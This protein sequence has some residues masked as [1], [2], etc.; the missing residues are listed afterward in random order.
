MICNAGRP[1]RISHEEDVSLEA[2]TF[3]ALFAAWFAVN[4]WI[5]PRLGIPT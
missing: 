1:E 4:R 2:L 3:V 5:L